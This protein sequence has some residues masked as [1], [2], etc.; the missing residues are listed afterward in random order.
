[1]RQVH[2]DAIAAP[3]SH[4]TNLLLDMLDDKLSIP[5]KRQGL[6]DMY[7]G[8]DVLQSRHYIRI[9][10]TSFITKIS[11]KYQSTWM[12][13]LYAPSARPTPLPTDCYRR[14]VV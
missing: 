7:N 12:K 8:V 2:D 11:E 4:T 10:C 14:Y 5:I 6:L 13:H 9:S 1:M 3:D